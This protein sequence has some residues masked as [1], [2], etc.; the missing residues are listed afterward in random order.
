MKNVIEKLQKIAGEFY[1][2]CEILEDGDRLTILAHGF[3]QIVIATKKDGIE[4][5][6]FK[7]LDIY[8]EQYISLGKVGDT[9]N[10]ECF[11]RML[12]KSRDKQNRIWNI[13]SRWDKYIMTK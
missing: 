8:S 11:E 7:I 6:E 3:P 13:N 2:N 10:F 5:K 4:L 1:W 9:L 12:K